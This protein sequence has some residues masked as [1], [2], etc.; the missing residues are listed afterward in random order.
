MHLQGRGASETSDT[1]KTREIKGRK[2]KKKSSAPFTIYLQTD[3]VV[4]I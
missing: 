1:L 4:C 2:E 3:G